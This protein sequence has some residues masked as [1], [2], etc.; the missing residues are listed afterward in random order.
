MRKKI[1]MWVNNCRTYSEYIYSWK[2]RVGKNREE[3]DREN[4]LKTALYDL[5]FVPIQ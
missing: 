5:Q 3:R 4:Y 1:L 2:E